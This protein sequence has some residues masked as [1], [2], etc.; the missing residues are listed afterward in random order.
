MLYIIV[1]RFTVKRLQPPGHKKT[2]TFEPH[3]DVCADIHQQ[4][5]FYMKL[6]TFNIDLF[7]CFIEYVVT[8]F[9]LL[10]CFTYKTKCTKSAAQIR[11][12]QCLVTIFNDLRFLMVAD[13][14]L[15]DAGQ[16]DLRTH[17]SL[18]LLV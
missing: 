7:Y 14:I 17:R 10:V 3:T 18:L 12:S 8:L 4:M 5:H 16:R 11:P 13:I 1:L 9:Y 2:L 15:Q 6:L